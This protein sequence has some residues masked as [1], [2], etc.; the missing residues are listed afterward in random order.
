MQIVVPS[1]CFIRMFYQFLFVSYL[2]VVVV[3]GGVEL[4]FVCLFLVVVFFVLCC[5][6]CVCVRACVRAC[7]CVCVHIGLYT[8]KNFGGGG[9]GGFELLGTQAMLSCSLPM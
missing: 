1:A 8:N 7:V 6:L 4:L 2:V 5:C 9:G 3:F